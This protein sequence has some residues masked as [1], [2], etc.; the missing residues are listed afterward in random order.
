MSNETNIIKEELIGEKF[1]ISFEQ[2]KPVLIK[3][4]NSKE[5]Y[6]QNKIHL[7][8]Y[9]NLTDMND[10]WKELL[11]DAVLLADGS[12]KVQNVYIGGEILSEG[13]V[14]GYF[15]KH[16]ENFFAKCEL[17]E[18]TDIKEGTLEHETQTN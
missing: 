14:Y 16:H 5:I 8:Y 17:P 10:E 9:Q 11:F 4:P 7:N 15:A 2:Y 1:T 6:K 12:V 13:I 18:Y 3:H